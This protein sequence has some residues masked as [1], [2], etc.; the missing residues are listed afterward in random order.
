[1]ITPEG[2]FT[3]AVTF[4]R[5]AKLLSAFRLSTEISADC[6]SLLAGGSCPDAAPAVPASCAEGWSTLLSGEPIVQRTA[7]FQKVPKPDQSA[8]LS[9]QPCPA[10]EVKANTLPSPYC[11]C[12]SR[13]SP[14]SESRAV[15]AASLGWV[16][17]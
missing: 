3:P 11:Q 8:H 6:V 1:M 13:G 5:S 4:A 9:P 16:M 2:D 7:W 10:S 14:A 17:S 15:V 12:A